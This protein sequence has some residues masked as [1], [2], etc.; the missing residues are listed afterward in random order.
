MLKTILLPSWL[1][2]YNHINFSHFQNNSS[3]GMEK[4]L[5]GEGEKYQS[6]DYYHKLFIVWS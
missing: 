6:V 5:L 1:S 4:C 2:G 3:W